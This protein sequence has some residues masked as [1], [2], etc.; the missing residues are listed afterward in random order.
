[1][2]PELTGSR[3]FNLT[4]KCQISEDEG[5][6]EDLPLIVKILEGNLREVDGSIYQGTLAQGERILVSFKSIPYSSDWTVNFTPTITEM[7]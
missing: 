2:M 5:S 6:G 1:M 4:P 3:D 7:S